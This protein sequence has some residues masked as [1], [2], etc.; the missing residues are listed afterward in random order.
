M[1]RLANDGFID[2]ARAQQYG[3]R[4][5]LDRERLAQAAE[6]AFV[7]DDVE[8]H[9]LSDTIYAFDAA[10]VTV[11]I[12]ANDNIHVEEIEYHQYK[13]Y[14]DNLAIRNQMK[15]WKHGPEMALPQY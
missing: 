1:Q 3:D 4:L 8:T 12:E 11:R 14:S 15:L 2:R 10:T 9:A 5:G 6:R 7:K 13:V